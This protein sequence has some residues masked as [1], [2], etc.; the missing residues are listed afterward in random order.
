MLNARIELYEKNKVRVIAEYNGY[1]T[2]ELAKF[3]FRIRCN[4]HIVLECTQFSE[5]NE[6]EADIT[7]SGYYYAEVWTVIED[8][9]KQWTDKVITNK[10]YC[11]ANEVRDKYEQWINIPFENN[12]PKLN[13]YKPTYPFGNIAV[14]KNLKGNLGEY[15]QFAKINELKIKQFGYGESELVV[16]SSHEMIKDISGKTC[17]F[18]GISRTKSN[19]IVGQKDFEYHHCAEQEFHSQIGE[20][21]M[22]VAHGDDSYALYS[23]YFGYNRIFYYMTDVCF[24]VSNS[25]HLLLILLKQMGCDLKMN[26]NKIKANFLDA[27]ILFETNY[28]WNMD[29]EGIKLLPVDK[30]IVIK[31]KNILFENTELY[32]DIRNVDVF[33]EKKYEAYILNAA[34]EITNNLK[35]AFEYSDYKNVRLDLTGG[36]DSRVVY[37]AATRLPRSY[38]E[39]LY[40]RTE[41]KHS[42][43][44]KSDDMSS[45]FGIANAIN[46][47]YKYKWD[48]LPVCY[49]T[50]YCDIDESLEQSPQSLFLGNYYTGW[51]IRVPQRIGKTIHITGG[52]G[53]V[54]ARTFMNWFPDAKN[55]DDILREYEDRYYDGVIYPLGLNSFKN[56]MKEVIEYMPGKHILEKWENHYLYFRNGYH[57]SLKYYSDVIC[58][59]WMPLQSKSSFKAKIMSWTQAIDMKTEMD[60]ITTMNPLLA[61]FPYASDKANN[62]KEK[63]KSRLYGKGWPK[64]DL[65]YDTNCEEYMKSRKRKIQ[66]TEC[67]P[68]GEKINE[69]RK[70]QENLI[71]NEDIILSCL[72][73]L[74]FHS[75]EFYELGVYLFAWITQISNQSNMSHQRVVIAHKLLSI[76]HMLDIIESE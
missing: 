45:D 72:K 30:Q 38:T 23:D 7:Y 75:K 8:G 9:E 49:T 21:C 12:I 2:M 59:A 20:Y 16:L 25:F 15:S 55:L 10:L 57:F 61:Q 37:S 24:V 50:D 71:F 46:N 13:L 28:S 70:K 27:S 62:E 36:M 53:E 76:N 32:E 67:I 66:A 26:K 18:S 69:M 43:E 63:L 22:F 42:G 5:K 51:A 19:L 39:K 40:I 54:C 17:C 52:G 58:L 1:E 4:G 74:V 29:I 14:I 44:I 56:E 3:C 73:R 31:G 47:V 6:I 65:H 33:D 11:I 64:I 60:L 41:V 35:I 34:E 68:N 48:E